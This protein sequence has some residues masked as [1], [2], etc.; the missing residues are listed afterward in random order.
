M[1]FDFS[2]LGKGIFGLKLIQ[3][4]EQIFRKIII[5]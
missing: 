4:Q 3:H 1:N 2:G 5:H